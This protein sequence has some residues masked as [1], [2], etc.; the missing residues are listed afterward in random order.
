MLAKVFEPSLV[1]PG[2]L[3][4][5]VAGTRK[6]VPQQ[7]PEAQAVSKFTDPLW[8]IEGGPLRKA[9]SDRSRPREP[10]ARPK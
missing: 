2:L 6:L 9:T 8:V 10:P 4:I 7:L 5:D 1:H 3:D